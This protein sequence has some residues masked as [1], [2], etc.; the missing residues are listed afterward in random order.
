MRRKGAVGHLFKG[1]HPTL[2]TLT[3]GIHPWKRSWGRQEK[4]QKHW[5][6][7]HTLDLEICMPQKDFKTFCMSS[8][9]TKSLVFLWPLASW[10]PQ[11]AHGKGFS[12]LLMQAFLNRR[13]RR[14]GEKGWIRNGR[15]FSSTEKFAVWQACSKHKLTTGHGSDP[16]TLQQQLLKSN[17]GDFPCAVNC[18]YN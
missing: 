15:F 11:Y 17:G 16:E 8:G 6:G 14:D 10:S 13:Q 12:L 3:E 2:E 5:I 7:C 4:F 9:R 18:S 1:A